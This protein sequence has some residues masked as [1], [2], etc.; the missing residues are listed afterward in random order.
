MRISTAGMQQQAINAILDQQSELARTQLQIASGRRISKPS[1]DPIG[2]QR[3]LEL[4]AVLE[5]LGQFRI[6]AE[7]VQARLGLE[8]NALAGSSEVLQRVRELVIQASNDTQ[9]VESR[10]LI[11]VEIRQLNDALMQLANSQNG[12][13]EFIFAGYSTGTQPFSQGVAGVTYNGDQGQRLLQVSESQRIADGDSGF[14]VFQLVKTGNGTFTTSASLSNTGSG[15]IAVGSVIDPVL[16]ADGSFVIQF[17]SPTT[18]DVLDATIS[19]IAT[20]AYVDGESIAFQGIQV[21]ITGAP[22]ASDSFVVA[23]SGHQD[24]FGTL[25]AIA[26]ALASA[27]SNSAARARLHN[28]LNSGLSNLDQAL[29]RI[30]QVR[31]QVGSRLNALDSLG[32]VND[33]LEIQLRSTLSDIRDLDFAEAV[34]R[35]N[36]QLTGLQAA[37]QV[38]ARVQGLSLFNFL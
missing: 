7:M 26:D 24:M 35:L 17:T 23:P 11:A 34:G 33:E 22:D 21:K 16:Y 20:G 18:Y 15:V 4:D 14:E 38:F 30:V 12:Q 36:L 27:A 13:G 25:D 37:Q 10:G 32:S 1:D 31:T 5:R 28:V 2:S 29:D 9:S 19:V 8:E 6:N 3:I